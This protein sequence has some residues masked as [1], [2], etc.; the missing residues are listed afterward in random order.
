MN[1]T[2]I[3]LLF[4]VLLSFL[5]I[6]K[7]YQ[8]E[9]FIAQQEKDEPILSIL[10]RDMCKLDPRIKPI[11]F[12][13]SNESYAEDKSRI[14]LCLK[15][16]N[17]NYYDYNVLIYVCI[18]ECAHVLTP[19]YDNEH[20]TKEFIDTFHNLLRKAKELNIY[21]KNKPFPNTYCGVCMK[22]CSPIKY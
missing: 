17:E 11:Q 8:Y 10:K 6:L 22:D 1:R 20:K 14:Y 5:F 18:H 4:L 16:E 19:I 21:N 2:R 15:D 9:E 13:S 7:I 12:Y 3:A